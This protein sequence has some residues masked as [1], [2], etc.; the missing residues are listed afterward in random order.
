MNIITKFERSISDL[1]HLDALAIAVSGGPDS[2]ALLYITSLWCKQRNIKLHAITID[3]DLRLESADEANYVSSLCAQLDVKHNIIKWHHSP[4][5]SS[6]IQARARKARYDF[7]TEYCHN[8]QITSLLTAHHADDYIENFFIRLQKSSG[9]FG[10]TDDG[11]SFYNDILVIKPFKEVYKNEIID[12]LNSKKIEWCNDI[13]NNN[14]KYL[15]S[16]IRSWISSMPD[17]LDPTLFKMRI[18]QSIKHLRESAEF[19]NHEFIK[20]LAEKSVIYPEGYATLILSDSHF[21]NKMLV[22]HLLTTVSGYDYHARSD[23]IE[24]LCKTLY[25]KEKC[26]VNLH[27]CA[28]ISKN[29]YL[30]ICR[31][32]GRHIPQSMNIK[33]GAKWDNRWRILKSI[34]ASKIDTLSKDE[35]SLLLKDKYVASLLRKLPKEVLFTIPVVRTLEK[36]IAIPHIGYYGVSSLKVGDSLFAFEPSYVSRLVHFC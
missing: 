29:D 28:V 1:N 3:H 9:L 11:L 8:N 34:A 19:I 25:D 13:S 23:S 20:N 6:N 18:S 12:Y 30:L 26:K 22:T 14:K 21:I 36:L 7:M 2:V 35:Y 27:G 24:Q 5:I 15:R 17:E 4:D 32:F 10:L 31:D 33:K 16:N